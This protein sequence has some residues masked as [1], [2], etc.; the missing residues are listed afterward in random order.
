MSRELLTPDT[1]AVALIDYQPQMFFG[2]MSHERTNILHNVQAIAKAAKL[3]K[4]PTI[5]TTVAAK[6][7]SGDMVPEVQSVFPE[8]VP[9]DRTSMNSW[10]DVNFRKA[11]EATGRKKIVISGLWTEVCVSFPTI[12][13]IAEGYEIY[14]PTDACGDV[15]QEAHE[16]AVQRIIQAGAVPMT[17]LQFMFELQRDWARSETYEGCM[18]ILKAHSSY[19]IGVRYAKAILGEHASEA[20]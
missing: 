17:S 7:F 11:I 4:V 8:Y 20:G 13:M 10:E 9:V 14:V 15:S 2:T 16:R 3:F 1:C 19:G 12:Q 5:L 18:D 6:S